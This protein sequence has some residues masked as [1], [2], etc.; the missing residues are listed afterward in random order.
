MLI[1]LIWMIW[2]V[3]GIDYLE[4]SNATFTAINGKYSNSPERNPCVSWWQ[5]ANMY[6]E[7]A[8]FA[9]SPGVESDVVNSAIEILNR[10]LD[11]VKLTRPLFLHSNSNDDTLW[12]SLAFEK[13]YHLVRN[14]QFLE[15][16]EATLNHVMRDWTET[17]GGGL[18]WDHTKT[19]KNAI[20]NSLLL[21]TSTKLYETTNNDTY[22]TIAKDA[23]LWFNASGM[24]DPIDGLVDDG[25]NDSPVCTPIYQS[26]P[27]TYNQGVLLSGLARLANQTNDSSLLLVADSII[28]NVLTS[29]CLMNSQGILRENCEDSTPYGCNTDQKIFKGVFAR[30]LSYFYRTLNPQDQ[31]ARSEKIFN[32]FETN[33][34]STWDNDRT[35]D[36]QGYV[37][38]GPQ[39]DVFIDD[40]ASGDQC[41][42]DVSAFSLFN[43]HLN[44][45]T[46]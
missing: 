15:L 43:A 3:S 25:L 9:L 10:M 46:I 19:Y 42:D 8:N 20:T 34:N 32:F 4:R 27:W 40:N 45:E 30:H 28:E 18:L 35:V 13:S 1:P 39:W 41:V 14:D 12:W 24:I 22:L 38:F 21:S 16:S 5:S 26:C 2:N 37:L 33:S 31:A 44:I 36:S 7:I 17:C 23:W 11:K 29:S 6:E